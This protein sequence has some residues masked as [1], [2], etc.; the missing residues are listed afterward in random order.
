M[1]SV[2]DMK[3]D[4]IIALKTEMVKQDWGQQQVAEL[5]GV[6]KQ[7]ISGVLKGKATLDKTIS[8]MLKVGININF[9][10]EDRNGNK[11]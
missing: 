9:K 5:C 2:E 4:L 8:I 6:S 7:Y 11:S 1:S 10:I 3:S